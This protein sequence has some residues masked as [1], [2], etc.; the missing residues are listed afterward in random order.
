MFLMISGCAPPEPQI[1]P[2]E[3]NIPLPVSCSFGDIEK[4][5]WNIPELSAEASTMDKLK[6]ALADLELSH[7]YI[8]ELEA[9]R[10]ACS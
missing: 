10:K 3:V 6:A 4:P 7:A 9:E 5:L 8:D 2:V 1:K